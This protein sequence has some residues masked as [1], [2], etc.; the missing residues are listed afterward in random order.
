V[1]RHQI[2]LRQQVRA[3]LHVVFQVKGAHRLEFCPEIGYG[4][5]LGE[6]FHTPDAAKLLVAVLRDGESRRSPIP[7]AM[8]AV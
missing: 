8:V 1:Y 5:R 2:A 3:E 6:F 4:Y 7:A